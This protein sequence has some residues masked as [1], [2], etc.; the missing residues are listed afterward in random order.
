VPTVQPPTP[1]LEPEPLS[2]ALS[3]AVLYPER[4]ALIRRLGY[5][6]D[7]VPFDP[8]DDAVVQ[9]LLVAQDPVLTMLDERFARWEGAP[10]RAGYGTTTAIDGD[11]KLPPLQKRT[12]ISERCAVP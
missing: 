8:P 4:A 3:Y 6:P 5:V 12:R 9:E 7:D 11:R 1:E 2:E 10:L